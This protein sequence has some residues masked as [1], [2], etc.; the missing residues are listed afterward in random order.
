[1]TV[2]NPLLTFNVMPRVLGLPVTLYEGKQFSHLPQ[3]EAVKHVQIG[4]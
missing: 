3:T 4:D 2:S 1:M